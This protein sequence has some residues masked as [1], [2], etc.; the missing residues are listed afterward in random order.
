MK[1]KRWPGKRRVSL[2]AMVEMNEAGE[3]AVKVEGDSTPKIKEAV[4]SAL[5]YALDQQLP[6]H[7]EMF[8][9]GDDEGKSER[10][11]SIRLHGRAEHA[12]HIKEGVIYLS[13]RLLQIPDELQKDIQYASHLLN[14]LKMVMFDEISHLILSHLDEEDARRI[15]YR[16]IQEDYGLKQSLNYVL[17]ENVKRSLMI[18]NKELTKS[19]GVVLPDE[20]RGGYIEEASRV[21]QSAAGGNIT[22]RT[23]ANRG[24]VDGNRDVRLWYKLS[25]EEGPWKFFET[26][27]EFV[28]NREDGRAVYE[29]KM[30]SADSFDY[31]VAFKG[32]DGELEWADLQSGN[33]FVGIMQQY[34]GSIAAIGMEFG[35]LVKVGGQGDVMHELFKAFAKAGKDVSVVMPY[36]A[37]MVEKLERYEAEDV[38]GV[39]IKIPFNRRKDEILRVKKTAIDGITV[40]MLVAQSEDMFVNPYSGKETEFYESILLSRGALEL[41]KQLGIRPEIIHTNDHHTALASLY[42][43]SGFGDYFARTGSIFTIHNIGYQGEY[44]VE[45]LPE[46]GLSNIEPFIV[47][48]GRLNFMATVPEV[49]LRLGGKGNYINTVSETYAKEI[50]GTYFEIDR[51]LQDVS[52]R[53]GGILNG[54]DFEVWNPATDTALAAN[55]DISKD[56]IEDIRKAKN[57]NKDVLK[58]LLSKRGGIQE[59]GLVTDKQYGHL[60]HGHPDRILVGVVSRLVDQKQFDIL[61]DMIDDIHRGRKER[62]G[63]DLVILGTGEKWLE[64]DLA[65]LAGKDSLERTVYV[66]AFSDKLA[67][68]IYA[69]ADMLLVPSDYEPSGINQQIA[70]RYGTLPLVRKTGGLADTVAELGSKPTGFVFAGVSRTFATPEEDIR[71][72]AINTGQLYVTIERAVNIYKNNPRNWDKRITNAMQADNRWDR[73]LGYYMNV[74]AWLSKELDH[75]NNNNAEAVI[76]SP[77]LNDNTSSPLNIFSKNNLVLLWNAIRPLKGNTIEEKFRDLVRQQLAAGFIAKEQLENGITVYPVGDDYQIVYAAHRGAD[78]AKGLSVE[79]P[80]GILNI[81]NNIRGQTVYGTYLAKQIWRDLVLKSVFNLRLKEM[82]N[83]ISARLICRW[84]NAVLI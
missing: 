32:I 75:Q 17:Q 9:E 42:M 10:T 22:L 80:L 72:R 79:N 15:L 46:I 52:N 19:L 7:K 84:P 51:L 35:P 58:K 21:W 61:A 74:Y 67:R 62:L 29:L 18:G 45:W 34:E 81:F 20:L 63:I 11:V 70:M 39:E 71:R 49:I 50:R 8:F 5:I 14:A 27:F 66:K 28:E 26:P 3:I 1:A 56:A 37:S 13:Y 48:S 16:K 30:N 83:V 76:S 47:K 2:E 24:D 33:G 31:T 60:G 23:I 38:E 68:M 65:E 77:I 36:F 64:D 25:N 41:F 73:S 12:A 78:Y 59:I 43:R 53:F 6:G 55:Y 54:I 82:A 40:Y 69:G 44:P 4:E 57:I